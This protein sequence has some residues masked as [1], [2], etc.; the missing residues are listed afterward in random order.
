MSDREGQSEELPPD[1][2]GALDRLVKHVHAAQSRKEKRGFLAFLVIVVYGGI[3]A[4]LAQTHDV[5]YAKHPT[6]MVWFWPVF[7]GAVAFVLVYGLLHGY[8]E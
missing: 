1:V 8:D 2:Q 4:N 6:L 5:V 7:L 3:V